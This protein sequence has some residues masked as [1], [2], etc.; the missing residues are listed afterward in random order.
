MTIKQSRSQ[1]LAKAANPD[2]RNQTPPPKSLDDMTPEQ[3]WNYEARKREKT[4]A[5]RGLLNYFIWR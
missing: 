1:R 2:K 4:R 5:A 3:L